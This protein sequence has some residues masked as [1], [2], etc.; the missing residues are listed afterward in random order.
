MPTTS[1]TKPAAEL[2]SSAREMPV[3]KRGVATRASLIAAA[4]TI[5][6][7]DGFLDARIS[8]IAAEASVATGSFYTYFVGKEDIFLA[9][10][11][12]IQDE[13]LHPEHPPPGEGTPLSEKLEAS[14]RAYLESYRKN[15]KLMGVLEQVSMINESFREHR[16]A[17]MFAF[18]ERN[19]RMIKRLQDDGQADPTLDPLVAAFAL[20]GMVSRL[21]FQAFVLEAPMPF[22]KIVPTVTQ[23]WL[24]ALQTPGHDVAR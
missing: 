14:N 11:A 17:R 7:R 5:F 12:Q 9:L 6:E 4:R 20:G 22:E 24:N 16:R 8:D 1:K 21:A 3:S 10:M 13:M 19:A 2:T 23:L 18:T 15:A